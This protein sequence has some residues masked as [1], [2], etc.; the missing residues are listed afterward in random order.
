[1]ASNTLQ[2]HAAMT[3]PNPRSLKKSVLQVASGSQQILAQKAALKM[4][5][6]S[7]TSPYIMTQPN[8]TMV[9]GSLTNSHRDNAHPHNHH[10]HIVNNQSTNYNKGGLKTASKYST[11]SPSTTNR[12][13]IIGQ[14]QNSGTKAAHLQQTHHQSPTQRFKQ[15]IVDS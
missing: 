8:Q 12:G 1:M 5:P 4:Q 2:H 13:S 15:N 11:Q 6:P 14:Q 3:S 10:S 9:K 7:C